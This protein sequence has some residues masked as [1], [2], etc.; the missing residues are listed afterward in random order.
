VYQ[1]N[2]D[3]KKA[4]NGLM[5]GSPNLVVLLIVMAV[6]PPICEELAFRGFILSGFRHL[7]HTWRAVIY[8]ALCFGLTHP[9][10]QQSI[11]ACLVGIVIGLLAVRTESVL[12]CIVFHMTHNA[13]AVLSSRM[14]DVIERFPLL[15]TMIT[16]DADQTPAYHWGLVA[17]GTA[18]AA[19]ILVWFLRLPYGKSSEEKL[20]AA[21]H[22]QNRLAEPLIGE[23]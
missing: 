9:I 5:G 2:P 8:S 6:V 22:R 17:A 16:L 19:M 11:L 10:I 20:E 7:G 14:S 3:V 23:A 18:V 21:I 12:P 1:L 15:R 4:L 13:L